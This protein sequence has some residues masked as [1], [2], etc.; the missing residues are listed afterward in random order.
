MI[1]NIKEGF[2]ED[3][4]PELGLGRRVGVQQV[5]EGTEGI[6]GSGK[7]VYKVTE[8]KINWYFHNK[9]FNMA[10]IEGMLRGTT[11]AEAG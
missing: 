9:Y 2:Q 3:V 5:E 7:G 10:G 1:S 4:S 8:V 11:E 6:L